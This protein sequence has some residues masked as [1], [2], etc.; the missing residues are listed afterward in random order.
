M[1]TNTQKPKRRKDCNQIAYG[2]M[3]QVIAWSEEPQPADRPELEPGYFL[4]VRGQG[5]TTKAK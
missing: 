3:Q 5:K 4:V 2:V 1:K